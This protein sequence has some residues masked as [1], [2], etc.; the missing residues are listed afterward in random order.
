MNPIKIKLASSESELIYKKSSKNKFK[1]NLSD[2][3]KK[4]RDFLQLNIRY[5]F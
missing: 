2:S 5:L 4:L 1:G 3:E